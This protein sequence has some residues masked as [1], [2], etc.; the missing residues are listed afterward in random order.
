[1]I[2]LKPVKKSVNVYCIMCRV[3]NAAYVVETGNTGIA[4]K[5]GTKKLYNVYNSF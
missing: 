2:L 4:F 1:V 3:V 5:A